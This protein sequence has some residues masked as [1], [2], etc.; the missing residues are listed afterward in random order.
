[1]PL[2]VG[3]ASYTRLATRTPPRRWR[4]S[5]PGHPARSNAASQPVPR[6][7]TREA[8]RPTIALKR[9]WRCGDSWRRRGPGAPASRVDQRGSTGRQ[10]RGEPPRHPV[11]PGPT[12]SGRHRLQARNPF[13]RASVVVSKKRTRSARGPTTGTARTAINASGGDT[14]EIGAVGIAVALGKD[15]HLGRAR[16]RHLC[17]RCP[18]SRAT[19]ASA[20]PRRSSDPVGGRAQAGLRCGHEFTLHHAGEVTPVSRPGAIRCL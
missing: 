3:A 15:F 4:W 13:W 12:V 20:R 17:L 6:L 1:M 19:G 5:H 18:P 2:P 7:E 9:R 10:T 8:D 16:W 11:G 14:V